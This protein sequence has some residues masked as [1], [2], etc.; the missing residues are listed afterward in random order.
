MSCVSEVEQPISVAHT[1][2]EA[3][4]TA[5]DIVGWAARDDWVLAPVLATPDGATRLGI[6]VTLDAPGAPPRMEA[7]PVGGEWAPLEIRWSEVDHHVGRTDFERTA[8]GVELRIARN[9]ASTIAE[10]Y[11]NG[12]IPIAE[13]DAP[14]SAIRSPLR[15]ELGDLGIVTRSAWG[16]RPTTCTTGDAN[17]TRIAI[18]HTV[19]GYTDP[20][21]RLRGIQN[22]H[23][24]TRGWC[25]VGYHFLVG[26][27]GKVY[28]GR[29]LELLGTHV[30]GQNTGNI[31]ISFIGCFNST[32]CSGLG[33]TTPAESMVTAA[34]RL[35]QR[36]AEIFAI[37]VNDTT[38]KGHSD[39]SGASTSC[40]GD[41]LRPR[42][43]DIRALAQPIPPG[44]CAHSFGGIYGDTACSASYQCCNGSWALRG[45][46]GGC[47][48]VE[49]T[50]EVGCT[51]PPAGNSCTHSFGGLYANTACSAS[52]QCCDGNWRTRE[53]C[54]A[55]YCTE[56]TGTTGCGL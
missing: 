4:A 44:G 6:L 55:C 37:P 24:D 40:P 2:G 22:Y 17:K 10:L 39:H 9:G 11:W 13:A 14:I 32:G 46:C 34:G 56:P 52:Y 21:R 3:R 27:D 33:P 31:G 48:C 12:V 25:D 8:D 30:S 19:T 45:A 23:M 49:P 15:S 7:R 51:G 50:G 20:P 35:S 41:N 43:P 36:L 16:A 38:L 54:G 28:E 29:P 42:L 47:A 53:T 26:S 5:S 18:H 1:D